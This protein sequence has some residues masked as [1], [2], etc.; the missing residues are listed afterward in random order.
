MSFNTFR[1]PMAAT[2]GCA[3]HW[4]GR[5]GHRAVGVCGQK[6]LV[7]RQ[8][9]SWCKTADRPTAHRTCGSSVQ[10]CMRGEG[11][12]VLFL[13]VVIVD[14]ATV[15]PCLPSSAPSGPSSVH[16]WRRD[17]QSAA[18]VVLC[19]NV[20]CYCC[21]VLEERQAPRLRFRQV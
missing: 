5:V 8:C 18:A 17:R 13:S 15:Q 7:Y 6:S 14:T 10:N 16:R 9:S 11:V 20:L 12:V 19:C 3:A 2:N 21:S 4:L 1:S